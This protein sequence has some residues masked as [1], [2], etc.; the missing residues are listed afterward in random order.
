MRQSRK[1]CKWCIERGIRDDIAKLVQIGAEP[2]FLI[3]LTGKH[4]IDRVECHA[5][6]DQTGS[7]GMAS[8]W[9]RATATKAPTTSEPNAA[10]SVTWLA[11]TPALP[12]DH[13]WPQQSLEPRFECVD[14][15]HQRF[16]QPPG[17]SAG[18]RLADTKCVLPVRLAGGRPISA[19]RREGGKFQ[20]RCRHQQVPA[21]ISAPTAARLLA[22]AP[23]VSLSGSATLRTL[24]TTAL[25]GCGMD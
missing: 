13:E 7:A 23:P 25:S 21:P 22:V 15:D 16:P 1:Q 4:P 9:D 17:L 10:A 19:R 20:P 14:G 2:A 8:G 5:D 11:V 18:R 24:A 6:E 12:A 3:V